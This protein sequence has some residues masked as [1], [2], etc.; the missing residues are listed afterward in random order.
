MRRF[1]V[2]LVVF[3]SPAFGDPAHVEGVETSMSDGTWRFNVTIS[4]PDTGW[5]HYADGWKI[6]APDGAILGERPLAHPHVNEQPF[7]RSLSGA[8]ISDEIDHVFI[9]ANCNVDGA[10]APHFR[11]D[12][13]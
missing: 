10:T 7:T 11:V 8:F 12:L 3:A 9:Q 6:L 5:E 13:N 1:F 2:A 4:H